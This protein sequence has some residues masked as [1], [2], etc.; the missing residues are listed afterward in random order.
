MF[1]YKYFFFKIL[2]YVIVYIIQDTLFYKFIGKNIFKLEILI[3]FIFHFLLTTL[4]SIFENNKGLK[5]PTYFAV[6]FVRCS[7]IIILVSFLTKK[8]D[9][10]IT[11]VIFIIIFDY[12]ALFFF[13]ITYI[14][15]ILGLYSK[16]D[17]R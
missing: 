13:E 15:Y 3:F 8:I 4:F 14:L 2:Y 9:K 5:I 10:N 11:K 12:L 7:C 16:H 1:K 6:G 17:R